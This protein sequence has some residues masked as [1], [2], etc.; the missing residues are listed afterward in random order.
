MVNRENTWAKHLTVAE[1]KAIWAQDSKIATW[2]D[3]RPEFPAQPIQLFS[4]GAGGGNGLRILPFR[5]GPASPPAG[6]Q[7]RP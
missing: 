1:I 7:S 6:G 3:V 2:P 4:P 5:Q